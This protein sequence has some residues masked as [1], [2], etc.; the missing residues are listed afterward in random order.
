[1]CFFSS[2]LLNSTNQNTSQ[3]YDVIDIFSVPGSH[4]RATKNHKSKAELLN[5]EEGEGDL[6]VGTILSVSLS[7]PQFHKDKPQVHTDTILSCISTL[8]DHRLLPSPA[9]FFVF[10]FTSVFSKG[11]FFLPETSHLS[12]AFNLLLLSHSCFAHLI[13]SPTLNLENN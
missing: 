8:S 2:N 3:C 9:L 12:P 4:R 5:P 1:M 13:L 10:S 7:H 6:A 11:F